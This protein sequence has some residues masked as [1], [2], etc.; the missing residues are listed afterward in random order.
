MPHERLAR[1]ALLAKPT[2]KRPSGRPRPRRSDC[3]SDLAC[4]RLGVEPAELSEIAVDREVFHVLLGLLPQR[5]GRI[6]A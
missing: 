6:Y 1:H 4:Y 2:A 5:Q 3:I